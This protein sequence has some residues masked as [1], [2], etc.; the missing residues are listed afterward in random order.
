M[1]TQKLEA[2]ASLKIGKPVDDVFEAIVDP[3]KMSRYFISK[4]T[5]RMESGK[6]LTW[7]FP[8]FDMTFPVE[9]ISAEKGRPISFQ[10]G[11]MDGS[12]TVVEIK[13]EPR[14]DKETFVSVK[15]GSK[16]N[17][18]AGLNWMRGNTEGWAN[19]LACLKAYLEYGINLRK[20]A[21]DPSKMEAAK[22]GNE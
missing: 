1:D 11:S 5:G 22:E 3:E 12:N 19:F 6:T 4:S 7:K 13:L 14:G 2:S 16:E 20:G 8:E 17:N 10:W 18:E 15:E 21:F 9:I